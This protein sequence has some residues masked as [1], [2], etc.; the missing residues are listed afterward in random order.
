MKRNGRALEAASETLKCDRDIVLAAVKQDG[1]ALVFVGDPLCRDKNVITEIHKQCHNDEN[2]WLRL[3]A[4]TD[5]YKH[6][7][8]LSKIMGLSYILS[9][10]ELGCLS[11]LMVLMFQKKALD[12]DQSLVNIACGFNEDLLIHICQY[13]NY[14]ENISLL[15]VLRYNSN[16]LARIPKST[17]GCLSGLLVS[18]FQKQNL[19]CDDVQNI[20]LNGSKGDLLSYIGK[21]LYALENDSLLR[22]LNKTKSQQ[23][24]R[25]QKGLFGLNESKN[26]E[27]TQAALVNANQGKEGHDAGM[28]LFYHHGE[29]KSASQE[30]ALTRSWAVLST[31]TSNMA[32]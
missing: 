1:E 6:V 29:Q 17:L 14:D 16:V 9:N 15:H 18:G 20:V 30:E 7:R 19:D 23:V 32:S 24:L 31:R 12:D 25:K 4:N 10:D 27:T 2:Y 21:Y 5:L 3:T 22:A 28:T 8:N 13:L 26:A 11:G